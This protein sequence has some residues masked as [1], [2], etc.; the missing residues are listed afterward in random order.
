MHER[1]TDRH[2]KQNKNHLN[3]ARVCGIQ[4]EVNEGINAMNETTDLRTVMM[5]CEMMRKRGKKA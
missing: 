3:Y 4:C 5:K 2:R 1:Q